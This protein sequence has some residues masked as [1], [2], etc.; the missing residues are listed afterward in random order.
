MVLEGERQHPLAAGD[1]VFVV[2]G[3]IHQFRNTGEQPLKFLCLVPNSSMTPAMQAA[4]GWLILA[5][6]AAL[7]RL[8]GRV[9][10]GCGRFGP[11]AGHY[12]PA[13]GQR[14]PR[15][16]G[17]TE[18]SQHLPIA[19]FPRQL[20]SWSWAAQ[21]PLIA[22]FRVTHPFISPQYKEAFRCQNEFRCDR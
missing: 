3:E 21:A 7:P 20:L 22:Q 16:T 5:L 14:V 11:G 13:Q 18:F 6:P 2:P 12:R 15:K 19:A 9:F 10:R 4:V 17:L 1:V 8:N